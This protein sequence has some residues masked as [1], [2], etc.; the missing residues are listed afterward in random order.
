[1]MGK[2]MIPEM[3]AVFNKLI[4][5]IAQD[6]FINVSYHESYTSYKNKIH[7]SIHIYLHGNSK[8]KEKLFISKIIKF[9][10]KC[11]GIILIKN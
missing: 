11:G 4:W 9:Q 1:M 2:E 10:S 7:C 3:S 8:H 6:D 5:L